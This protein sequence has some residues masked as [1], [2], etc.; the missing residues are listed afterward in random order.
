M[1][2]EEYEDDDIELDSEAGPQYRSA[3]DAADRIWVAANADAN[4]RHEPRMSHAALLFETLNA[5][6]F[7]APERMAAMACRDIQAGRQPRW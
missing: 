5:M 7:P 6:R 4:K 2:D 1:S 3:Y